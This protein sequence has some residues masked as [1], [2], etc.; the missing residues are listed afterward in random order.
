MLNRTLGSFTM[1]MIGAAIRSREQY[2]TGERASII[3]GS[4]SNR[5]KNKVLT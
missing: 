2:Y 4:A 1:L 5:D 3:Q